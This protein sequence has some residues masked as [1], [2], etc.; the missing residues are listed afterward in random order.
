M[1]LAGVAWIT[2]SS[3]LSVSVLCSRGDGF[4][5]RKCVILRKV[6]SCP[7][8]IA[9]FTTYGEGPCGVASVLGTV[10]REYATACDATA[11]D[12]DFSK[13]HCLP[14]R[15]SQLTGSKQ[16]FIHRSSRA[17]SGTPQHAKNLCHT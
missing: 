12:V 7:A 2:C 14:V 15:V 17:S 3:H 11:K 16:C 1:A 6:V 10:N 5:R 4:L 13:K 8:L 9:P